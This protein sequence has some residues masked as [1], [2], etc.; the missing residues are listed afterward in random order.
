MKLILLASCFVGLHA[1]FLSP[2]SPNIQYASPNSYNELR[3]TALA[4]DASKKGIIRTRERF[5]SRPILSAISSTSVHGDEGALGEGQIL[6]SLVV[7]G[8]ISGCSAAYYLQQRGV[9][10]LLAEARDE[11]GGNI[12]TRSGMGVNSSEVFHRL[13]RRHTYNI[14]IRT[15]TVNIVCIHIY[16]PRAFSGRRGPIPSSPTPSS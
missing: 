11:L 8:G 13:S 1:F 9:N 12:I 4:R 2:G 3:K 5:E 6:D 15:S 7:G 14:L 10:C 16:Q